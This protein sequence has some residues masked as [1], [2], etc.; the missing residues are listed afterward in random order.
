[1]AGLAEV[2]VLGFLSFV[3]LTVG[4]LAV[5]AGMKSWRDWQSLIKDH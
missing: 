1:M 4:W 3:F 2:A 5:A